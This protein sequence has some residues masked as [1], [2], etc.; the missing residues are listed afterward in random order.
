MAE[1]AGD[2]PKCPQLTKSHLVRGG[3]V[4]SEKSAFPSYLA[5]NGSYVPVL[6]TEI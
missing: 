5:A 3:S 6:A 1:A 2:L 4:P